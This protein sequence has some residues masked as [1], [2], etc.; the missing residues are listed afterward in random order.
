MALFSSGEGAWRVWWRNRK[1]HFLILLFILFPFYA[2]ISLGWYAGKQPRTLKTTAVTST[3]A[4]FRK[5]FYFPSVVPPKRLSNRIF[6]FFLNPQLLKTKRIKG[7]VNRNAFVSSLFFKCFNFFL[8]FWLFNNRFEG[9][10]TSIV[11][12]R[13]SQTQP[14]LQISSHGHLPNAVERWGTSSSFEPVFWYHGKTRRVLPSCG[15]PHHRVGSV[16]MR[17]PIP[18]PEERSLRQR[19]RLW[20]S[21]ANPRTLKETR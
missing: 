7:S 19:S 8:L 21:A 17:I 13:P 4:C 10:R 14:C 11:C 1:E 2:F 9:C 12:Q 20:P 6:F 16:P 5:L 18:S 3:P 15:C